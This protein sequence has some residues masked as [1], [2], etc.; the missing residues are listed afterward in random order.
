M[1]G[2][3]SEVQK[4]ECILYNLL[5]PFRGSVLWAWFPHCGRS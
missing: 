3:L 4:E 2:S 1:P 5:L